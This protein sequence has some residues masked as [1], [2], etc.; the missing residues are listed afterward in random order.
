MQTCLRCRALTSNLDQI[1]DRCVEVK[2]RPL[3]SLQGLDEHSHHATQAGGF[4][5][6]EGLRTVVTYPE[7]AL[8]NQPAQT[9]A[10]TAIGNGQFDDLIEEEFHTESLISE[11]LDDTFVGDEEWNDLD[12][13]DD[14]Q[15]S[16]EFSDGLGQP[17]EIQ[18]RRSSFPPATKISPSSPPPIPPP[19]PPSLGGAQWNSTLN[20]F[21]SQAFEP[22]KHS[23]LYAITLPTRASSSSVPTRKEIQEGE[24]LQLHEEGG[25]ELGTLVLVQGGFV[26]RCP[27]AAQLSLPLWRPIV[28]KAIVNRGTRLRW[29]AYDFEVST[30]EEW[31]TQ[32]SPSI[33]VLS[34]WKHNVILSEPNLLYGRFP[35]RDGVYRIG[36]HGSDICLPAPIQHTPLFSLE[37]SNTLIWISPLTGEG[38]CQVMSDEVIPFGAS[39]WTGQDLFT[40]VQL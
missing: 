36:G 31:P 8:P 37:I 6:D 34:V 10:L 2:N 22:E 9:H 19:P 12:G 13:L 35:L 38:W 1:C 25:A 7:S 28:A 40:V 11:E 5:E 29:G 26:I 21:R 4:E 39:I 15:L 24:R 3:P 23:R 14:G 32:A 20:P 17:T 27:E 16:T 33:P 30:G 18:L